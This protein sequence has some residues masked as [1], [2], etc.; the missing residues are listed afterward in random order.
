MTD[1]MEKVK[2]RAARIFAWTGKHKVIATLLIIVAISFVYNNV[3]GTSSQG[4]SGSKASA[5]TNSAQDLVTK[6]VATFITEYGTYSYLDAGNTSELAKL[7]HKDLVTAVVD[8]RYSAYLQAGESDPALAQA[9]MAEAGLVRVTKPSKL[10]IAAQEDGSYQVAV[11][12]EV[13]TF[14]AGTGIVDSSST[15]VLELKKSDDAGIGSPYQ[16]VR[17]FKQS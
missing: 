10:A 5:S 7:A 17:V 8:E 9:R 3:A 12:V 1:R 13:A 6:T 11:D 16:V 4:A 14:T 2:N 15:Y